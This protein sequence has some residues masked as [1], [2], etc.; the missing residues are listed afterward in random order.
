MARDVKYPKARVKLVGEDGNAFS[1]M[2][3]V[4]RA[5]EKAKAPPED[6]KACMDEM[7][8]GDYGHL[9]QTAMAWC[10]CR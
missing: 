2:A 8:S 1:I 3:R 6:V 4:R 5:L 7:Q 9:L 10:D